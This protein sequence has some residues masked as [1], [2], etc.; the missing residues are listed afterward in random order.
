MTEKNRKEEPPA[1]APAA[2]PLELERE[3]L[4]AGLRLDDEM[5]EKPLVNILAELGWIP[6]ATWKKTTLELH[7]LRQLKKNLARAARAQLAEA[8]DGDF[9]AGRD[10]AARALLDELGEA[11]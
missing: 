9:F 10:A 4:D 2:S 5:L 11:E 3:L 8:G 7:E 1:T 6:P